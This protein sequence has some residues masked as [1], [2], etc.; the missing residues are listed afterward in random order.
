MDFYNQLWAVNHT[1]AARDARAAR[2]QARAAAFSRIGEAVGE[3]RVGQLTWALEP[4]DAEESSHIGVPIGRQ[5]PG[6]AAVLA[7]RNALAE[8]A[9]PVEYRTRYLGMTRYSGRG[10][11]EVTDGEILV[12][13]S[14]RS[15]SG[16]DRF[17]DVPVR[18]I[19]GRV[20][21]PAVLMDSGVCRTITQATLDDLLERGTFLA[22]VDDRRTMFSPPPDERRPKKIVP[23]IRPGLFGISPINKQLTASYVRAAVRGH[24]APGTMSFEA[25]QSEHRDV[26]ERKPPKIAPG[27]SVTLKKA[28]DV[29]MRDGQRWHLS[30]GT[31]GEVQRDAA[32]DGERYYVF[33]P[34]ANI[35]ALVMGEA[36]AS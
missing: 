35:T 14:F 3:T 31:K 29:T 20:L 7:V 4:H 32:S 19:E 16:I 24:C 2:R 6:Y 26:G 13:L 17:V 23:L 15:L 1:D 34:E 28:V 11:Y 27:D 21:E 10:P 22:A 36:L 30:R 8:Y 18:I 12:E 25:A 5:H 9:M 33:F